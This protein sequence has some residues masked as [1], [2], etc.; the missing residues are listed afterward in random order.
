MI[1]NCDSGFG[2]VPCYVLF[3]YK[4]QMLQRVFLEL[5]S[6][7][8]DHECMPSVQPEAFFALHSVPAS[9]LRELDE[10]SST[11]QGTSHN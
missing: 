4:S 11:E 7:L 8:D 2:T 6:G 9:P 3:I 10:R 5:Q 1:T